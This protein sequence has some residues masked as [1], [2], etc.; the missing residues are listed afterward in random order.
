[1]N[2]DDTAAEDDRARRAA[3]GARDARGDA[4]VDAGATSGVL[5]AE[6]T[7]R[8]NVGR[9]E[10]ARLKFVFITRRPARAARA[11]GSESPTN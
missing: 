10:R 6:A 1:M 2:D 8:A 11:R 3:R 4:R 9:D 5:D 7:S